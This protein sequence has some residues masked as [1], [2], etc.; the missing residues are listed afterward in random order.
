[1]L[2]E[3]SING[4]PGTNLTPRT[5]F[6]KQHLNLSQYKHEKLSHYFVERSP[7]TDR[8]FIEQERLR[9]DKFVGPIFG[10][11]IWIGQTDK[12]PFPVLMILQ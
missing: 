9:A 2:R 5:V 7:P 6:V 8:Y 3:G 4:A 10:W 12:N 11:Q 1:M